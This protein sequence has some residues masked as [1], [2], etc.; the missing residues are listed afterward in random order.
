[1]DG[2]RDGEDAHGYGREMTVSPAF[3]C[4]PPSADAVAV[5]AATHARAAA[6]VDIR[7]RQSRTFAA[8]AYARCLAPAQGTEP[9]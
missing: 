2:P 6:P 3:A 5:D 4:R 9:P 1:M 7:A 8:A